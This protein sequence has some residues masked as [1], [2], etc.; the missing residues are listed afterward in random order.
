M[1]LFSREMIHFTGH[2]SLSIF[3]CHT[4]F[5]TKYIKKSTSK[6]KML[7]KPS[8]CESITYHN[9]IKSLLFQLKRHI[10]PSWQTV[11]LII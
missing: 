2:L 7:L 10:T 1:A 11:S 9:K 4:E 8:L 5:F 6:K 3:H